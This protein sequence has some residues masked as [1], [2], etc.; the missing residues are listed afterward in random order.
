MCL[1][2]MRATGVRDM[3]ALCLPQVQSE[4]PQ[5][6]SLIG[7][8]RQASPT[9]VKKEKKDKGKKEKEKKEKKEKKDKVNDGDATPVTPPRR[10]LV[11]LAFDK[12]LLVLR[13]C[14]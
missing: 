13:E 8:R 1:W 12:K 11:F 7:L 4:F 5:M 9:K 6:A 2:V 3:T 10:G 14:W